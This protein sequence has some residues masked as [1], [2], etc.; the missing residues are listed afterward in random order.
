MPNQDF[1]LMG[2]EGLQFIV[3]FGSTTNIYSSIVKV[4]ELFIS[5]LSVYF[6]ALKDSGLYTEDLDIAVVYNKDKANSHAIAVE[7]TNTDILTEGFNHNTH[8]FFWEDGTT[9][10]EYKVIG[11][12]YDFNVEI[13]CKSFSRG[14]VSKIADSVLLGLNSDIDRYLAE[15]GL[16]IPANSVIISQRIQRVEITKDVAMWEIGIMIPNVLVSWKQ[17]VEQDGDVL[18]DFNWYSTKLQEINI[19]G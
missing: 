15:R 13:K 6:Q 12:T 10:R 7:A 9:T 8:P 14:A 5:G 11:G 3:N 17:V 2:D 19:N 4:E 16:N 1:I 18:K